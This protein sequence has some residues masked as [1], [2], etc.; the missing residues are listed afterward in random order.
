MANNSPEGFVP[1]LF[2]PFDSMLLVKDIALIHPILKDLEYQNRSGF[3]I[4]DYIYFQFIKHLNTLKGTEPKLKTNMGGI[5]FSNGEEW[6]RNRRIGLEVMNDPKFLENS[7]EPI[8]SSTDDM[9]KSM[10]RS[11]KAT[12]D[13]NKYLSQLGIDVVGKLVFGTELQ[14]FQENPKP[15]EINSKNLVNSV[16][17]ML[18]AIQAYIYIPFPAKFY[19]FFKTK[20][21]KKLDEAVHNLA[22]TGTI[23]LDKVKKEMNNNRDKECLAALIFHRY[24][25][26]DDVDI[27]ALLMDLLGAGHDTTANLVIFTLSLIL[28]SNLLINSDDFQKEI[29]SITKIL[30]HLDSHTGNINYRT[31][32]DTIEK[33]SPIMSSI[34]NESL[35]LY[36]LGA[37]FSRIS[38]SNKEYNINL[39][40]KTY[41]L[42]PGAK[43]LISPYITGR[44]KESWGE[45]AETFDPFRFLNLE[46]KPNAFIPFGAGKRSCIGGRFGILEARLILFRI[47]QLCKL[48]KDASFQYTDSILAF[49]LRT[50]YP[51]PVKVSY[52]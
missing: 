36:P 19:S 41:I 23:L 39:K 14:I 2:N 33:N 17:T 11:K 37:I 25:E 8:L 13:I 15:T 12:Q 43:L 28:E 6:K 29:E 50:K 22:F 7:I 40:D 20:A 35:R 49:T 45:T 30:P 42:K 24:P 26:L 32:L 16:L 34:L 38:L 3:P 9:I 18:H 5:T 27:Q 52:K 51:V 47:F 31:I 1:I 44:L 48:E 10:I 46:N 21:I 4:I